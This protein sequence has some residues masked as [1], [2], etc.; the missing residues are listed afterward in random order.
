V[1]PHSYCPPYFFVIDHILIDTVN[2]FLFK[3]LRYGHL[4]YTDSKIKPKL[5]KSVGTCIKMEKNIHASKR[6][7][8]VFAL[9]VS[10]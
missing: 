2:L 6:R 4:Y 10:R 7:K 5:I 1:K 9:D 3:L 8:I